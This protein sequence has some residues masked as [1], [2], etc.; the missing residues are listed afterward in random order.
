[1]DTQQMTRAVS[2][3]ELT[4]RWHEFIESMDRI[5]ELL[6]EQNTAEEVGEIE[7]ELDAVF[8]LCE[9]TYCELMG[10]GEGIPANLSEIGHAVRQEAEQSEFT[11]DE[12]WDVF[13]EV[14]AAHPEEDAQGLWAETLEELHDQKRRRQLERGEPTTTVSD[15]K[16]K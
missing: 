10:R 5:N 7:A 9:S 11:E 8:D 2:R 15:W 13:E 3:D 14:R 1:M 16:P 12:I 6:A 4:G